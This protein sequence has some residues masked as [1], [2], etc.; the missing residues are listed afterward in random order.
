MLRSRPVMAS[1]VALCLL[2]GCAGR[3]VRQAPEPA[4]APKPSVA[5]ANV[6]VA[7]F[8]VLPASEARSYRVSKRHPAWSWEPTR[9]QVIDALNRLPEYLRTADSE[10]LAH[11]AY[12]K[13]LAELLARLPSTLC[14][15]SGTRT[16]DRRH[17]VFLNFFPPWA[18]DLFG[19][20]WRKRFVG[21]YDAGPAFW[22]V[23]YVPET[24]SCRGLRMDL[25][26]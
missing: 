8:T 12:A 13:H 6:P 21:A 16:P 3:Q 22:S 9:T 10:P 4:S 1:A 5:E 15:A 7:G 24:G 14:Q 17:A 11:P 20:D 18:P 19:M 2:V 23:M 25:G 26:F